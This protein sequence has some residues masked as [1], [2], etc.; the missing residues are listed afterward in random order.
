[1]RTMSTP[2]SP[3]EKAVLEFLREI[4]LADL[5]DG[6]ID[7]GRR[8]ILDLAGIA[9]DGLSTPQARIVRDYVAA[10]ETG[11]RGGAR[12][13]FDGRFV[14][15]PGAA[16]ANA[17]AIESLDGHDG[18]ALTK[19]HA[20]VALLPAIL[21]AAERLPTE[22]S[23]GEL[24]LALVKGYEIAIRCGIALHAMA[25]DYHSSGA[26]NSVATALVT[27]HLLGA[28]DNEILHAG[29]IAEYFA[30]RGLMMRCIAAPSM[31]KDS[32]A[33]GSRVGLEAALL[34]RRG[35]SGRPAELLAGP[36]GL[37]AG[38]ECHELVETLFSDLGENWRILELYFKRF[39]ICRWAQPAVEAVLSLRR[40]HR[41]SPGVVARVEVRSFLQAVALDTREPVNT[42]EAQYSLPYA[43]AAA[44]RFGRLTGQEVDG[45]ALKDPEVLRLSRQVQLA[46]VPSYTERFPAERLA[47]VV[48]VLRDGSRAEFAGAVCRGDPSSPLAEAELRNKFHELAGPVLGDTRAHAIEQTVARMGGRDERDAQ[49][50]NLLLTSPHPRPSGET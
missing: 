12:L 11:T 1:M 44:L 20:G 24:L 46:E 5:P 40:A 42:E 35:F 37:R 18:H 47:D 3:S 9:A 17:T 8:C 22:R 39:P 10:E 29:G 6:V 43:V 34:A 2:C 41:L 36:V 15:L 23:D 13:L 31:V 4:G 49:L 32:S 33:W 28:S 7:Q 50:R 48:I 25:A 21:A 14:S 26:W 45:G 30:P 27:S 19:G 16:W 38:P